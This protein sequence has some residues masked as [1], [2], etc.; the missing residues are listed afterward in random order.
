MP[1]LSPTDRLTQTVTVF[2]GNGDQVAVVSESGVYTATGQFDAH[3]N[4]ARVVIDLL[5]D[6]VHHLTVHAHVRRIQVG[7]CVMGDYTLSTQVDANG[8]PLVIQQRPRRVYLP[9]L[10]VGGRP[11]VRNR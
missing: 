6:Q 3:S 11:A 2:I 4:P 10:V 9:I 1:V 5:P 7:P 8:K